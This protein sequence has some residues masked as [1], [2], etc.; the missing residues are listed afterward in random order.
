MLSKFLS[1]Q[2]TASF[3]VA[4]AASTT[5]TIPSSRAAAAVNASA[6][7][8]AASATA[9]LT[10]RSSSSV[11]SPSSLRRRPSGRH[12]CSH[13][14]GPSFVIAPS[15]TVASAS[16]YSTPTSA[17]RTMTTTSDDTA[18]TATTMAPYDATVTCPALKEEALWAIRQLEKQDLMGPE[19][20]A[21]IFHSWTQHRKYLTHL[22][23]TFDKAAASASASASNTHPEP[24][25]A[26]HA[27]A[28]KTNPHP[29]NLQQ[30]V[31]WGF[32]LECASMEEVYLAMQ[33]GCPGPKIVFDSPVKTRHEL[34]ICHENPALHGIIVNVN[35]VEE[36]ERIPDEPNFVVG[37]RI[38][39]LVDTGT[40]AMFQVSGD[41]SKFGTPICMDDDIMDA[42]RKY[43]ITQLHVHSGT[44]MQD[45]SVAVEAITKVVNVATAAN[46]MLAQETT[47]KRRIVGVDIGGGLRP[48]VF[49][50]EDP[51][52]QQSRMEYYVS[53]L[54]QA[55]PDLFNGTLKCI[56]EFGAWSY[57]YSGFV[58]S[59]VEYALQRG[60]TTVAY[61]HVG[62]DMFLR[63]IYTGKQR[64][65]DFVPVKHNK[66]TYDYEQ[67][68]DP[69]LVT[70]DIAGPLCFAGDYLQQQIEFPRL[71]EGDGLLLLNT[72]SNAY[73]LWSRHCSRTTPQVIGVDMDSSLV[74]PMSPRHNPYLNND[75]EGLSNRQNGHVLLPYKIESVEEQDDD[76]DDDDVS[77][78][79]L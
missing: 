18:T 79:A 72:G 74:F 47:T 11:S 2:A 32:G 53:E 44:A 50:P 26:L 13:A 29:G 60:H 73:G 12:Y 64:G 22:N 36:L 57:F 71:S 61:V 65:I 49:T 52:R 33:A 16:Q 6:F 75:T 48:E 24:Q 58:Y 20:T 27:I 8:S 3:L 41:E 17:R 56:T 66:A 19:D 43:P 4:A 51:S 59:Q 77:V 39:P 9:F 37:L 38:N 42:I 46:A 68:T 28:V 67:I 25:K 31:Q 34:R 14:T 78:A 55:A 40:S 5:R 69:D 45:L 15:S 1:T 10:I 76:D 21:V 54:S 63:D 7:S 30:L 35:C 23:E 62:A 70:T